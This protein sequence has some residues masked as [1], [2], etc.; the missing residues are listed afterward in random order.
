MGSRGGNPQAALWKA[1]QGFWRLE[2]VVQIEC[3]LRREDLGSVPL[4]RSK[5]SVYVMTKVENTGS[6]LGTKIMPR[7]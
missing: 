4:G 6:F 2:S 7:G 1:V 3:V 5:L